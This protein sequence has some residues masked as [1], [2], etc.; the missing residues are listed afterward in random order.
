MLHHT[1]EGVSRLLVRG[2]RGH[3]PTATASLPLPT[4]DLPSSTLALALCPLDALVIAGVAVTYLLLLSIISPLHLT[5][6]PIR[7]RATIAIHLEDRTNANI[8]RSL[9]VARAPLD[10]DATRAPRTSSS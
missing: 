6:S 8:P 2:R 10:G 7:S 1:R 5:V 9:A 4:P 3:G